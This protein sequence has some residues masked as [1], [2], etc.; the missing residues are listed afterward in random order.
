[1]SVPTHQ[2]DD[3]LAECF[4]CWLTRNYTATENEKDLA[5]QDLK[6]PCNFHADMEREYEDYWD[7]RD[8]DH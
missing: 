6:I 4:L 3:N 2:L 8:E 1:M 7:G 5:E